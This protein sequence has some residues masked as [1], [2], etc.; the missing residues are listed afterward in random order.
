MRRF[1]FALFCLF[2]AIAPVRAAGTT[3]QLV[4][5]SRIAFERV[6]AQYGDDVRKMMRE[7]KGVLIVPNLIKAGFFL[8]GQGGNGVLLVRQGDRQWSMPAFYTLGAG[9]LGLQFG[10]QDAEM[11]FMIRTDKA[12]DALMKDQAKLGVDASVAVW[13]V[14]GGVSAATTTNLGGDIVA[15]GTVK[16]LFGGGAFEG[17]AIIRRG[18]LNQEY[19]GQAVD[20]AAIVKQGAA[21]NPQADPLRN[22]LANY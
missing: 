20:A 10:V 1:L 8:G 11:V 17:G 9:S 18:D 14:G 2:A 7:A 15:F 12:L 4:D 6:M 22:S 21:R 19:Y 3:E 5:E 13:N 16:G